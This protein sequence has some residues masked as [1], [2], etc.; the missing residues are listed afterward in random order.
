MNGF[1][2]PEPYVI[3]YSRREQSGVL[4]NQA[5]LLTQP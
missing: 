1:E 3:E 4:A 5:Y 2:K